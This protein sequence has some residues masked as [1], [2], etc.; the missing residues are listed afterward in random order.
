MIRTILFDFGN[1]VAFFDHQRAIARLTAFTDM[2]GP[3]LY[4]TFYASSLEEA[5]E[6]GAL[7]TG[8]F[9]GECLTLGRLCCTDREFLDAFND[10]FSPNPDI[11]DR[12]PELASRYRLILASNTNASHFGRFR[13]QFADV[14]KHFSFLGVSHEA[15]V[16]KPS[17]S[18]FDYCWRHAGCTPAEC[19]FVDDLPANVAGGTAFGF[20]TMLYNATEGF[21]WLP[22][23]APAP[24]RE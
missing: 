6:R 11:I 2:D 24:P 21:R 10:I 5:Y 22:D 13:E 8:D 17:H 9:V 14:L 4:R 16:R 7:A 19:L 18:F 12:I 1:V 3:T 15:G 23:L 20:S